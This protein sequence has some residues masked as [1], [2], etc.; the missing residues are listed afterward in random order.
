MPPEDDFIVRTEDKKANRTDQEISQVLGMNVH[1]L[2]P[3]AMFRAFERCG[4]K[5][6]NLC[7]YCIGGNW[8]FC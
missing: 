7:S 4:I 2:S 6:E 1:F 3:L 5:R 8:P